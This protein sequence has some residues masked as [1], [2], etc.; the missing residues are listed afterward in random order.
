MVGET[1]TLT[2]HEAALAAQVGVR[3]ELE[4]LERGRVHRHGFQGSGWGVH[5][6][7]A[8]DLDNAEDAEPPEPDDAPDLEPPDDYEEEYE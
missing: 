4:A 7:G 6:E 3:R 8:F 1:V 5:I 2:R